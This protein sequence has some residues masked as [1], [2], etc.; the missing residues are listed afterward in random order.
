M[1]VSGLRGVKDEFVVFRKAF[2]RVYKRSGRDVSVR[3]DIGALSLARRWITLRRTLT[4]C[5]ACFVCGKVWA[6][7]GQRVRTKQSPSEVAIMH[8][9]KQGMTA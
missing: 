7:W 1:L 3:S 2:A 4:G 8:N 6:R 9:R 5:R